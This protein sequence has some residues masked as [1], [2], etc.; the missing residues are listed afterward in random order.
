MD[1]F[2]SFEST[3]STGHR[4][5]FNS[6]EYL[7]TNI[8]FPV[9]DHILSELEHRFTKTNLDLMKSVQACSLSSSSFLEPTQLNYLVSFYKFKYRSSC[10]RVR[11]SKKYFT[12]QGIELCHI[13]PLQ[14]AF[15]TFKKILQIALTLAV[16]TAQCERS[17]LL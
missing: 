1:D 3:A 9:L 16:S 11:A 6:S 12:K 7:K 17:F 4:E 2:V 14:A 10:Q 15:P 5:S 8:W 13:H